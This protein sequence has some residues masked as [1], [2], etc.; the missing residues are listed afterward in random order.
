MR[1]VPPE[2]CAPVLLQRPSRRPACTWTPETHQPAA[3]LRPR[4]APAPAPT[5]WSDR[6]APARWHMSRWHKVAL[7]NRCT[8]H[9]SLRRTCACLMPWP[10]NVEGA[11]LPI[12]GHGGGGFAAQSSA[13]MHAHRTLQLASQW[14]FSPMAIFV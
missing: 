6:W 3:H 4:P 12:Y 9:T 10:N 14:I 11:P 2:G 7:V 13:C 1:Q 5:P 8:G